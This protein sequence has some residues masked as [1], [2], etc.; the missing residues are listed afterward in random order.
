MV[1]EK[2]FEENSGSDSG[3]FLRRIGS[4]SLYRDFIYDASFLSFLAAFKA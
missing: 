4:R 3:L 2:I 1:I